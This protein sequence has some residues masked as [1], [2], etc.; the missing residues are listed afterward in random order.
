[1]IVDWGRF[2]LSKAI[3]ECDLCQHF[4]STLVSGYYEYPAITS[5]FFLRKEEKQK[6][7]ITD[8]KEQNYVLEAS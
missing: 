8:P 5:T 1:M 7:E 3:E 6:V 4:T 2:T